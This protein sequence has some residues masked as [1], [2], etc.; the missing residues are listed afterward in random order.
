MRFVVPMTIAIAATRSHIIVDCCC[1]RPAVASPSAATLT[2]N[3][4]NT[5]QN[6]INP[7]DIYNEAAIP[8]P[9]PS[10]GRP[11]PPIPLQSHPRRRPRLPLHESSPRPTQLTPRN[12]NQPPLQTQDRTNGPLR[13]RLP[14]LRCRCLESHGA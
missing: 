5:N 14:L 1:R 13:P 3:S 11:A 2:Y 6:S 8:P 7:I 9:R 10:I 12:R 4:I